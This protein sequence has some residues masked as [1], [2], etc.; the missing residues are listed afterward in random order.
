MTNNE[1]LKARLEELHS[2][3]ETA[4]QVTPAERDVLTNLMTDIVNLSTSTDRA[5]QGF[6]KTLEEKGT[7]YE[8]DHPKLPLRYGKY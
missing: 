4:S 7:A 8:V 6:K 2:E 3:L 1:E 5:E